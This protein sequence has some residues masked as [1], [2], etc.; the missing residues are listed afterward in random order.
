MYLIMDKF[1]W[2]DWLATEREKQGLSQSDLARAAGIN[3]QIINDYESHKRPN[4][5]VEQLTKIS[6]ALGYPPEYLPRM[7]GKLPPAP[8]TDETLERIAHLY[9]ALKDPGNKQ[10]ALD[11]MEFLTTQEEKG[12][13]DVSK[14]PQ[15]HSA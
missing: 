4:P 7:A 3:R 1:A 13:Y 9:H 10:R 11:F 2:A 15:A 6:I 8:A 12:K 5:Q 14:S